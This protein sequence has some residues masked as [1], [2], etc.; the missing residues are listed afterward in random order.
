MRRVPVVVALAAA[1][2][3]ASAGSAQA[4]ALTI[5]SFPTWQM[6]P[7]GGGALTYTGT[8]EFTP[9]AGF[10]G[11]SVETNS[12]T[13]KTPSGDSAWLGNST[14]FGA[15]FGSSRA[16]PYLYLSPAASGPSTTTIT[17]AGPPPTGWGLAV[18]DIDADFVQV[19]PKDAA[20]ATLPGSVLH[21][22]DT[23]GTPLLN[24]CNNTPK[25]SSCTQPAPYTDAPR[26][27]VNGTT[28]NGTTYT[29]PIVEGNGGDTNGSYDWFLPDTDVRSITL[30]FSVKS[31]FPIYQ[32]WLA[33]PAT[34]T[35]VS[36]QIVI[37]GG[38]PAPEGT[39]VR[40]EYPDS[41]PV[42]DIENQPLTTPV[43]P[44][45]SFVIEVEQGSYQL[46]FDVPDGFDPIDPVVVDTGSESVIVPTI[47]LVPTDETPPTVPPEENPGGVSPEDS[48]PVDQLP[49][50]GIDPT[51]GVAL[52]ASALA[53]G[54]IL[55]A[56]RRRRTRHS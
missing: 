14:G 30:V 39:A 42:L 23:G 45:G 19:I 41:T 25:P 24:Y 21:A 17:F 11:V 36:G 6:T 54:G 2:V 12:T 5:G 33:A 52:S 20:G 56:V 43:E 37:P 10:P 8:A 9:A 28:I 26:W 4:A 51:L 49:A 3:L 53:A 32:V 48:T 15:H 50:T 27:W 13:V 35:T 34:A 7:T 29:T 38:D 31:G 22:Q 16:Q 40:L 47:E 44:D 1:A 55:L 18:G 46:E